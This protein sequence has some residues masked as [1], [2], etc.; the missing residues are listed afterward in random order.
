MNKRWEQYVLIDIWPH[1]IG[2]GQIRTI[3]SS[4]PSPSPSLSSSSTSIH[5]WYLSRPSRPALVYF[6]QAGVLF[7]KI[8]QNLGIYWPIMA[9][10]L[11]IYALFDVLLHAKKLRWCTKINIRYDGLLYMSSSVLIKTCLSAPL[12][13]ST[14]GA[15]LLCSAFHPC[16]CPLC[17]NIAESPVSFLLFHRCFLPR[18]HKEAGHVA[19]AASPAHGSLCPPLPDQLRVSPP[20]PHLLLIKLVFS[21]LFCA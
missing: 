14:L 3:S 13:S 17:Q 12:R 16:F 18:S 10:L 9:I 7:A 19:G 15:I 20:A 6:F 11:P 8:M 2:W 21:R 1:N 5:S 4:S